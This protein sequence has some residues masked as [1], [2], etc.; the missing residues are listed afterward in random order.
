[1]SLEIGVSTTLANGSLGPVERSGRETHR[2]IAEYANC[3]YSTADLRDQRVR[4]GVVWLGLISARARGFQLDIP[5]GSCISTIKLHQVRYYCRLHDFFSTEWGAQLS[6]RDPQQWHGAIPSSP[7]QPDRLG[8]SPR[9]PPS[10]APAALVG[11]R[12]AISECT[13][14]RCRGALGIQGWRDAA[15]PPK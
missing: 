14:E 7:K 8:A 13:G 2:R 12:A 6:R 5:P 1:M 15:P 4:R 9:L 10:S 11:R 3:I